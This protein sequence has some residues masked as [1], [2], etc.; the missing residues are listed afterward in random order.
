MKPAAV[1]TSRM[2][3]SPDCAPKH[4]ATSWEREIDRLMTVQASAVDRPARK[5]AF[6]A[7]QQLLA[8][9]L[10][11]LYLVNPHALAGY[12][13]QVKG[14]IPVPARP[15]LFWNLPEASL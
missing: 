11:L 5:K 10:P 14:V 6:G 12:S 2:R 15:H 1:T 8:D 4:N 7:V 13:K 3:F 9:E